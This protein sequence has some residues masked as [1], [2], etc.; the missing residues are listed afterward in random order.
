MVKIFGTLCALLL[1]GP[2]FADNVA[3]GDIDIT[4]A[5]PGD[6]VPGTVRVHAMIDADPEK[7]W[8]LVTNINDWKGWMP[9]VMEAHFYSDE[10]V[11]A[12]P[13]S[14]NKDEA[15]FKK[16]ETQFPGHN[17]APPLEG[18][19][20]RVA[21][22]SYDLPWPIANNWS[23]RRYQY[24]N[25][26]A[27]T[28]RYLVSFRKIYERDIKGQEGTW[29]FEPMPAKSGATLLTY[30]L[31]TKP[32]HGFALTLFKIGVKHTVEHM[33]AAIRKHVAPAAATAGQ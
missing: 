29:T 4:L 14:V 28:H 20:T 2:V 6:D 27:A 33:I 18:T 5:F 9:M 23:V 32:Q 22:E 17:V 31:R 10:F 21:F 3:N 8:A 13:A 1:C 11:K 24:D 25:S 26:Q 15:L 19:S 7:V 16:L 30:E 12:L